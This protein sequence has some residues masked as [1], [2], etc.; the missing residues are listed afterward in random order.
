MVLPL[1][2]VLLL[3]LMSAGQLGQTSLTFSIKIEQILWLLLFVSP[4]KIPIVQH[5]QNLRYIL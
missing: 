1:R 4:K 2:E 3:G 5:R